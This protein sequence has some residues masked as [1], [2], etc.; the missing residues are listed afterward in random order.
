[1]SLRNRLGRRWTDLPHRLVV[2]CLKSVC[3]R[4]SGSSSPLHPL[5][6]PWRSPSNR[7]GSSERDVSLYSLSLMSWTPHLIWTSPLASNSFIH[8]FFLINTL[9]HPAFHFDRN[10]SL[11]RLRH[12][13]ISSRLWNWSM[14]VECS[15]LTAHLFR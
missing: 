4:G 7:S 15:V 3:L 12:F 13:P 10:Y 1:M 8:L 9:T 5:P 6:P 14:F 2:V 11:L